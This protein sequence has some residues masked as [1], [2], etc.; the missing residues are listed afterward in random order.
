MSLV[1]E[2]DIRGGLCHAIHRYVKASDKY[3]KKYDKNKLVWISNLGK[4]A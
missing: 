1:V 4:V 2:N 3:I